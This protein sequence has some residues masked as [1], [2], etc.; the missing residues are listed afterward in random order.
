MGAELKK[1]LGFIGA[2]NMA[3]ALIR[4]MLAAGAAGPEQIIAFDISEARRS[5]MR[6]LFGIRVAADSAEAARRADALILAVKP[7]DIETALTSIKDAV[8][9]EALV[10]SIAAGVRTGRLER[11]L[12]EGARVIR[13]MPNTPALVGKGVCALCAGA[14][15][16]TADMAAARALFGAVGLA[17]EIEERLMDAVTAVSGSGPAYVFYLAEAMICAARELGLEEAAARAM[18]A[19]VIE[20][21]GR[22]LELPGADA[23][24]LRARVA[25]KGGTTEAAMS[26]LEAGDVKACLI[27][28]IKAAAARSAELSK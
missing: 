22:M 9:P 15:A 26:V 23:E 4:G 28:A 14:R 17:L 21:A 19:A 25:S 2:G 13:V 6:E 24:E 7:K 11:G 5:R 18:T 20:G 8:R 3:E 10:L 27:R 12:A 1:N 16:T